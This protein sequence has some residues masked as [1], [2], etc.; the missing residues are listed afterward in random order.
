MLSWSQPTVR[1]ARRRGSPAG[2]G[3]SGRDPVTRRWPSRRGSVVARAWSSAAGP[4]WLPV[5]H[6]FLSWHSRVTP[7]AVESAVR[8]AG[9]LPTLGGG[10]RL[11]AGALLRVSG[12]PGR[13]ED[14][15]GE[16]R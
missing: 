7:R 13:A 3:S 6:L 11:A 8:A 15:G 14:A 16:V 2:R 4:E 9:R 1:D 10:V 5:E 12:S